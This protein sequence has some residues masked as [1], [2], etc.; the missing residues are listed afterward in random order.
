MQLFMAG[1][2]VNWVPQL[3]AG[4]SPQTATILHIDNT[5]S[6]HM[7]ETPDQVTNRTK[8]INIAY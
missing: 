1:H 4:F 5:S 3:L 6:I 7:I 8:H 2:E